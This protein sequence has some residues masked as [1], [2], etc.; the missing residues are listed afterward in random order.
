[1]LKNVRAGCVLALAL[2]ACLPAAGQDTSRTTTVLSAAG[3]WR[4]F[5]TLKPPVVREGPDLRT[6]PTMT[7]ETPLPP[8]D[9][10]GIDFDDSSWARVP[11]KLFPVRPEWNVDLSYVDA[12][13]T[14]AEGSSAALAQICVRGKFGV[15]APASVKGLKVSVAYRGGIVVYVNGRE[16]GRANAPKGPAGQEALAEDYGQDAVCR[17]SDGSPMVGVSGVTATDSKVASPVWKARVRRAE[18]TI[19]ADAL[20]KGGNVLAIEVRRAPYPAA[21]KSWIDTKRPEDYQTPAFLWVPCGLVEARLESDAPD[22]L[23]PNADRPKGLQV[24]NSQL[25]QPD[26]DLDYGDPFEPLRPIRIIGSRGGVFAGKVVVGSDQEIKGLKATMSELSGARGVAAIPAS[27]VRIR[28]GLPNGSE[29]LGEAHYPI[30]PTLFDGLSDAAPAVIAIRSTPSK[31]PLTWAFGAVCPIWLTVEV[32]GDAAPGDYAG[33]LTISREDAAPDVK[34][35]VQLRVCGWKVPQPREFR[36]IVDLIESPESVAMQY[37][38]PLYGDRHF[39]LLEK[40]LDC[41]GSVGN[42]T[43]HIPLICQ[44]NLGNEQTMVRWVMSPDGTY[45]CDLSVMDRYLDLVEKH[46]GKPRIVFL[47]VWDFFL[48]TSAAAVHDSFKGAMGQG[49]DVPVSLLDKATGQVSTGTVGRYDEKGKAAWAALMTQLMAGLTKRGL[50]KAVMLGMADDLYPSAEILAFW[51]ELLPD[52]PWGRY[53]HNEMAYLSSPL[54]ST[55]TPVGF[56]AHAWIPAWS[57]NAVYGW[58]RPDKTVMFFRTA[59]VGSA[60]LPAQ[61]LTWDMARLLGELN[62]QGPRRGF[63]RIGMDFWPVLANS[64]GEKVGCLVGRYPKSNW[65]QL[66]AMLRCMAPPGPDGAMATGKL[67]VMREGLQETEARI[68][69]ES[70]L[71]DPAQRQ[72]LGDALAQKAQAVLEERMRAL[73]MTL[74]GQTIAGFGKYKKPWLDG[75]GAGDFQPGQAGV[76]RQWYM[77][78]GWQERSEKVFTVAAEVAEVTKSGP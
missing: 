32:P 28:Y 20:R 45:Q 76:F 46:M 21:I 13:I 38:V 59:Y 25:M 31:I 35:P 65:R 73:V 24:W 77:A 57:T 10:T 27:A 72:R 33:T 66:E 6:L 43:V 23:T 60:S 14:G 4:L 8:A 63:G 62:I 64:K 75:F 69:L 16:V 48:G 54:A 42:W 34:V 5:Y 29:P 49:E 7:G 3:F 44:S 30:R 67:Q 71:N 19:P 61:T 12:G 51:K 70:A 11:G 15:T 39:K 68:F 26:F 9:W 18:M 52:A 40:S 1:M 2:A 78:S 17:S 22:G 53:G 36:T 50:D 37:G 41:M 56:Q 74:E 58:K 55:K 47:V